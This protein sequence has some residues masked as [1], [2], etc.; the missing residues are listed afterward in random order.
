AL[1]R[2]TNKRRTSSSSR[3]GSQISISRLVNTG[4]RVKQFFWLLETVSTIFQGVTVGEGTVQGKYFNKIAED[5]RRR[6][7]GSAFD[8]MLV[9]ATALHGYLSSPTGGGVR[10][11]ADLKAGL[12][13]QENDARLYCNLIRSY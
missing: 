5:L 3:C 6:Q 2:S 8:Q 7:R 4:R 12:V 11:G 1:R 13:M 9:W 10:H